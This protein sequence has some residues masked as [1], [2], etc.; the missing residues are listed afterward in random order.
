MKKGMD[1]KV[2]YG[3]GS[4]MKRNKSI[5]RRRKINNIKRRKGWGEEVNPKKCNNDQGRYVK[6]IKKGNEEKMTETLCEKT[7]GVRLP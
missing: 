6:R 4:D 1:K 3:L 2:E 7:G 5:R